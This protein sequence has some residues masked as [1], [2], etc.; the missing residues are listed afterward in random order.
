LTKMYFS[1]TFCRR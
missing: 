1:I